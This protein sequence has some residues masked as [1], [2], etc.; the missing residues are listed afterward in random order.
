MSRLLTILSITAVAGFLFLGTQQ[1]HAQAWQ[2][3]QSDVDGADHSK[4]NH[5]VLGPVVIAIQMG[6]ELQQV[7]ANEPFSLSDPDVVG[8]DHS[9]LNHGVLGA[10]QTAASST[11]RPVEAALDKIPPLSSWAP[12]QEIAAKVQLEREVAAERKTAESG[13]VAK[14]ELNWQPPQE[15]A[16]RV[17]L[18]MNSDAG[19]RSE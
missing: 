11:D 1:G 19:S 16:T 9:K 10:A 12:P 17:R 2:S 3:T 18:G 8:M 5:G 6:D 4:L 13:P 7:S 14:D 15:I